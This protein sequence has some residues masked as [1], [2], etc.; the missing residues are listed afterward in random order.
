M[1]NIIK[2]LLLLFYNNVVMFG[3]M[4]ELLKREEDLKDSITY[5]K[6]FT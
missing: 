6:R 2:L 3:W 4:V 1:Y 5:F